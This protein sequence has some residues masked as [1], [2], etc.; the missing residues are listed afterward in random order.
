M[1]KQI[2]ST[3]SFI[4]TDLFLLF[5]LLG[6]VSMKYKIIKYKIHFCNANSHVLAEFGYQNNQL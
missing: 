4:P 3:K 6:Q 1:N 5:S 2:Y